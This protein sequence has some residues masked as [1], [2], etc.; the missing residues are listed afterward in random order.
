MV[1]EAASTT[2]A[3]TLSS[4]VPPCPPGLSIRREDFLGEDFSADSFLA[5]WNA[6]GAAASA[7]EVLARPRTLETL[8]DDLG[9][10]LAKLRAAMIE[11]INEDYA[12]F[13]NLSTNLV[14]LDKDIAKLGEPLG[15]FRSEVQ[16]VTSDLDAALTALDQNLAKRKVLQGRKAQLQNLEHIIETLAKVERLLASSASAED[17][18]P[19]DLVERVAAE[20]NHLNFCV[21]K[22]TASA[23]VRELRPRLD[24]ACNRLHRSLEAQLLAAATSSEAN[25][26][27]KRCLR[28][29]ASIG[30]AADA[31][32]V[33][34]AR[35]VRPGLERTLAESADSEGALS[36]A[37]VTA[38]MLTIADGPLAPLLTITR[39]EGR[40][41]QEYDFLSRAFFPELAEQFEANLNF[42]FS[43]GNPDRFVTN[44][45][46]GEDLLISLEA[47]M[48]SPD[49]VENF[50]ATQAYKSFVNRWNLPI[51]FQI[52]FQEIAY[53]VEENL[54]S[55]LRYY[56]ISNQCSL[57]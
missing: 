27:L 25:S 52:R 38:G 17:A 35:I 24:T 21:S 13:V 3:Q 19:G 50:R 11:L 10:Y 54:G 22:C 31:E 28:V 14:G 55:I 36:L 53:P 51:Y 7:D 57:H 33:V 8:R 44:F 30:R 1:S 9:A 39:G 40:V 5:R 56:I 49:A 46:A 41:A 20:I 32:A 37:D 12:D 29:Y 23:L 34:R 2:M 47:R 42:V 45:R 16:G 26:E 48:G 15:N 43:A 18:L 6:A 4:V